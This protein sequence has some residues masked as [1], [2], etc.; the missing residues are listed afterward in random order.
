MNGY[1]WIATE[2]GLVKYSKDNS[3]IFDKKNGL[4]EMAF[5]LLK[6]QNREN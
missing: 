5:I 4:P 2:N 3:K 1:I 6:K